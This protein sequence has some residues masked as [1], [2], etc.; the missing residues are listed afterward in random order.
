M[1]V[2]LQMF[3]NDEENGYFKKAQARPAAMS[4]PMTDPGMMTEMLKGNLLNVLP[5]IVIGGWIN[6]TFSGFVTTKVTLLL[7]AGPKPSSGRPIPF[8]PSLRLWCLL[9]LLSPGNKLLQLTTGEVN[10]R[11]H[12]S[13]R[14]RAPQLSQEAS[15]GVVSTGEGP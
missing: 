3:F 12:R 11:L 5:M 8:F 4:N 6:W 13:D 7:F 10:D 2:G 9:C 14:F 15:T 1:V